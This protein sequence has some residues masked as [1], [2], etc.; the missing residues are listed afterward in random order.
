MDAQR[1][2]DFE[3]VNILEDSGTAT[4]KVVRDKKDGTM[5]ALKSLPISSEDAKA[6][7][8]Q[9][10]DGLFKINHPTISAYHSSFLDGQAMHTKR[11]YMDQGSLFDVYMAAG[12]LPED[13]LATIAARALK[14]LIHLH[15]DLNPPVIHR[16]I[17]PYNIMLNHNGEVKLTDFG[18]SKKLTSITSSSKT[19]VGGALDTKHGLACYMS[20]ERINASKY[21]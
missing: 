20:P 14:G 1:L 18:L 2:E 5:V 8:I 16:N 19:V 10:M 11:E 6:D 4:T 17:K 21:K 3:V 12:P 9:E 13:V 15:H 7:I